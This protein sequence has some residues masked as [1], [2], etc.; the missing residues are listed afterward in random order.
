MQMPD[1]K[2]ALE[3]YYTKTEISSADIRSLFGCC[4]STATKL[5]KEVKEAMAKKA[6]KT[7]LPGNVDVK[8]A[9]EVWQIDVEELEKRL[10]KLNKL[11]KSQVI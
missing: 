10:A 2:K 9:Y 8:T 1:I 6:I 11:K 4:P 7:W 5:K 3:L